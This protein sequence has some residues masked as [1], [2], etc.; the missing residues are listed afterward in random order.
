MEDPRPV[1]PGHDELMKIA[2]ETRR[3]VQH[4]TDTVN[5]FMSLI[6]STGDR[7]RYLEINGAKI[8]QDNAANI[9]EL[10]KRVEETE[11]FM[12]SHIAAA[13]E[14]SKIA[15]IIAG[16][17]ST[18]GVIIGIAISLILWGKP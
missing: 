9:K 6:E 1:C 7:V 10:D 15:A 2:F 13:K 4:L 17:I 14:T 11:Q 3:D 16:T 5:K 8:S 18:L 12:D